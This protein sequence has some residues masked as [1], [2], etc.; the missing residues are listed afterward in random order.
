MFILN[1]IF[2]EFAPHILYSSIPQPVDSNNKGILMLEDT[3]ELPANYFCVGTASDFFKLARQTGQ[4]P[5][6]TYF[7]TGSESD[8]DELKLYSCNLILCGLSLGSLYNRIFCLTSAWNHWAGLLESGQDN[9]LRQIFKKSSMLI[10]ASICIM[11]SSFKII[12]ASVRQKDTQF[13]QN[14]DD[15]GS[16]AQKILENLLSQPFSASVPV[17]WAQNSYTVHALMPLSVENEFLGFLYGCMED[18]LVQL[19][20][21]LIAIAYQ[22][23][24]RL[25]NPLNKQAL[26][27]L[28]SRRFR[29][30]PDHASKSA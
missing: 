7:L 20:K 21:M 8:L 10:N 14:F 28:P 1:F 2:S 24:V 3:L 25:Q 27:S 15:S 30:Y 5:V 26:V 12:T 22:L 9:S 6:G 17:Y 11:N 23:T 16:D 18:S 13:F 19:Q 29:A 4:E